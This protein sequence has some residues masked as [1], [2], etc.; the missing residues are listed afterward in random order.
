MKNWQETLKQLQKASQSLGK[1]NLD[2]EHPWGALRQM[3]QIMDAS[4]WEN[5][6]ALS[7][8]TPN[9]TTTSTTKTTKV[10]QTSQKSAKQPKGKP[11]RVVQEEET[12]DYPVTDV[13]L[14]EQA[15]IVCCELPGFARDSLELALVEQKLLEIKGEVKEP[16]YNGACVKTERSYGS[17]QR[18]IEL[19]APVVAKGMKAQYQDGLLEIILHRDA[20][21]RERKTTFKAKL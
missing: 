4:F 20:D 16:N 18:N 12:T 7:K 9:Q 19:P 8:Q 6:A 14:S 21:Y 17:F 11:V 10:V 2:K 3:N 15:V 5:V 13:F 1:L